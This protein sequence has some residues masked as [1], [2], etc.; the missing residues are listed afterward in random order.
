MELRAWADTEEHALFSIYSLSKTDTTQIYISSGELSQVKR[1][2]TVS[3]TTPDVYVLLPEDPPYVRTVMDINIETKFG[4]ATILY[5]DYP[6]TISFRARRDEAEY[7]SL[8]YSTDPNFIRKIG[9]FPKPKLILRYLWGNNN[10]EDLN[11]PAMPLYPYGISLILMGYTLT[12]LQQ[13]RSELAAAMFV[14]SFLPPFL[15]VEEWIKRTP[16]TF[17]HDVK[18]TSHNTRILLWTTSCF[19]LM[20]IA[21]ALTYLSGLNNY[22]RM[23]AYANFSVGI[24]FLMLFVLYL[25]LISWGVLSG[26]EC[27]RGEHHIWFR[28]KAHLI[29]ETRET[30]CSSC[31]KQYQ[32]GERKHK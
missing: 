4:E 29:P 26:Y 22:I 12:L 13:G 19:V 23:M 27:D 6:R 18:R 30:V 1:Q 7:M 8:S 16:E 28:G 10:N 32:H 2:L 3:F 20:A 9:L 11:A 15:R 25:R 21:T 5:L 14:A 31:W 24:I 17:S